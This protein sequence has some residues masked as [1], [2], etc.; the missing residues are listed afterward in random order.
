MFARSLPVPQRGKRLR[1]EVRKRLAALL[2]PWEV[3]RLGAGWEAQLQSDALT[4]CRLNPLN[5]VR[6]LLSTSE[7]FVDSLS[8]T[9]RKSQEL[10]DLFE[11]ASTRASVAPYAFEGI[12]TKNPQL[13][14]SVVD[15]TLL[16]ERLQRSVRALATHPGQPAKIG[17]RK[18]NLELDRAVAHAANEVREIEQPAREASGELTARPL[19]SSVDDPTSPLSQGLRKLDACCRVALEQLREEIRVEAE[20]ARSHC[21]HRVEWLGPTVEGRDVADHISRQT[22][23][24]DG[25]ASLRVARRHFYDAG[26]NEMNPIGAVAG[27]IEP[28]ARH[29]S[30]RNG[31]VD[32]SGPISGAQRIEHC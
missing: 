24:Q 9:G 10:A 27:Q 6:T 28:F 4:G 1:T 15:N 11:I 3:D 18:W 25:F 21:R 17:L 16:F 13:A 19:E 29:E 23:T 31:P 12:G 14:T 30:S 2:S 7:R 22:Q 5:L 26:A 32:Q 8:V 20:D